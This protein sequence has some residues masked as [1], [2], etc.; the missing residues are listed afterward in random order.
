VARESPSR[1]LTGLWRGEQG[2][3]RAEQCPDG[4]AGG[5]N[6]RSIGA[7]GVHR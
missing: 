3:R 4:Y 1:V 6:Q 2:G 5:E 7:I